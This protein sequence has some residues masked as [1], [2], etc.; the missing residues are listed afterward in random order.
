MSRKE[1]VYLSERIS[2]RPTNIL[3]CNTEKI[4]P[5]KFPVLKSKGRALANAI[6]KDLNKT[7]IGK[8]ALE[9]QRENA[10]RLASGRSVVEK[11]NKANK[12]NELVRSKSLKSQVQSQFQPQVKT[13]KLRPILEEKKN[14]LVK[15]QNVTTIRPSEEV[16]KIVVQPIA[17]PTALPKTVDLLKPL[18]RKEESKVEVHVPPPPAIH[19]IEKEEEENN[20]FLLGLYADDI[21]RFLK[22]LERKQAIR[23]NYLTSSHIMTHSM[24]SLLVDWLFEVQQSFKLLNETIHLAIA[25][26]DLFMQDH[27]QIP[28]DE[29]QLVGVS[30]IFL[31]SKYEEMYPPDLTDLVDISAGTYTK[32]Q[33]TKM[34]QLIFSAL[35]FQMGRPSPSQFLRRYSRVG[36]VD[37]ITYSLAKYFIDL[38]LVSYHLCHVSPSLIA[39][40]ALFLSLRLL[41]DKSESELW[42]QQLRYYSEYGPEDLNP[43][44]RILA[45]EVWKVPES[46][47]QTVKVKYLEPKRLHRVSSLKELR[48]EKLYK[49]AQEV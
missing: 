41:S 44:V 45:L 38:S 8:A 46:K 20:E 42:N 17:K 30:C 24:R 39:A 49:I 43:V 26:L 48:S 29:L 25:I 15:P 31:A 12:E 19:L 14:K 36:N 23:K 18:P 9:R 13:S 40:S 21:H 22:K 28:K 1:R 6:N 10:S 27:P 5:P 47:Y 11:E 4:L 2:T 35:N 32:Q 33:I 7:I 16:K 37:L 34:E 3:N